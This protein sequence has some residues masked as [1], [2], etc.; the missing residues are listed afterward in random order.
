[1]RTY[2]RLGGD[3]TKPGAWTVIT[4]DAQ[5]HNDYVWLVT[6][7]QCLLLGQGESPFYA[8]YGIPGPQ[9]VIS[10]VA[11]DFFVARTQQQFAPYFAALLINRTSSNPPTYKINVTF[12]NGVKATATVV[13]T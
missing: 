13:A 2:A 12:N 1:M 10:Q 11:P 6:L 5:G 9:A 4:T 3:S 7:I 8:Q